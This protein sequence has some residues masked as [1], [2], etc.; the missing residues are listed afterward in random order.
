MRKSLSSVV[1][2]ME[3]QFSHTA[4]GA[5]VNWYDCF[6]KTVWQHLLK[7]TICMPFELPPRHLPPCFSL[8]YTFNGYVYKFSKRHAQEYS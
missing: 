8:R 2:D 4:G 3:K 6:A 1:K 5:N 7:P